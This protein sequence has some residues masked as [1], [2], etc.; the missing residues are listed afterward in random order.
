MSRRFVIAFA[1]VT[2]AAGLARAADEGNVPEKAVCRACEVRGAGHGEEKVAAHREFEGKTYYFCAKE[3]A[4]QFDALPEGYAMRPVPRAA[5]EATVKTVDDQKF[6]IGESSERVMLLD[7][8]AS[9]CVPCRKTMPALEKVQEQY[10]GDRFTVLGVSID[11]DK[12]A[13]EK[14]VKKKTFGYPIA[15]DA[16]EDAAWHAFSVVVIPSMYLIDAEG[17]IVG[18]WT[19]EIDME[20]VGREIGELL[21][22]AE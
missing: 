9:W 3:C 4:E 14:F 7:F 8:W 17:K 5:P 19:G 6:A 18:E 12:K 13:F 1:F 22:M 20:E 11:E 10:G 16:K 15:L 21:A 2:L